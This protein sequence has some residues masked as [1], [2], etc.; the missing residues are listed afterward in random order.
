MGA[1]ARIER[2]VAAA[3]CLRLRSPVLTPLNNPPTPNPQVLST[4]ARKG[5]K[6]ADVKIAV[7]LFAFDCLYVNGQP[8]LTAPLT[9]RREALYGA[10]AEVPG[11]FEYAKYKVRGYS[12]AS[13]E[14]CCCWGEATLGGGATPRIG[15]AS[16]CRKRR[17]ASAG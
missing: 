9:E 10:L 7:C 1:A 17:F 3:F 14:Y 8:L 4:R 6:L 5:V 2:H 13:H 11:E 15:P 12:V 16:L